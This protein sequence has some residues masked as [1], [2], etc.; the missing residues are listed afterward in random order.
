MSDETDDPTEEFHDDRDFEVVYAT[1]DPD[2]LPVIESVLRA[3]KIP[4]DILGQN[5][6]GQLPTGVMGGPFV[7]GGM[8]AR[9]LV[10]ADYAQAARE[11][12]TADAAVP[13]S[14]EA[15]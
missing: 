12:L 13:E 14:E 6:I 2:V 4:F 15:E 5:A 9:F 7:R 1:A 10:P 8:A 3:S 11:L